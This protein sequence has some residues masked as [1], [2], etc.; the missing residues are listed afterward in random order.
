MAT[1]STQNHFTL[2]DIVNQCDSF[3]YASDS[4]LEQLSF[5]AFMVDDAPVGRIH[6]TLIPHLTSFNQQSRPIFHITDVTVAFMPWISD[7]E[8]RSDAIAQM[9]SHWRGDLGNFPCLSGWRDEL[10]GVYTHVTDPATTKGGAAL[11]IERSACGLFGVHAYGVHL[12]GYV[13]TGPKPSDVQMWVARRSLTK[14][15]Y[16]GML[17]NMV[18]GGMGFGHSPRYTVI[19]ESMEEATIPA[20]IAENAIP[21]GTIS[22][23][24][25][26]KD[27]VQTQPETQIVYDLELPK[28]VIPVP[29]DTEVEDFRLWTME[30]VLYAIRRGEFKPN[31]ACVCLH[32]MIQHAVITPENEPDYLDIV[33]RLH[34]RIE[35]PGPKIWPTFKELR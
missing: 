1:D 34:R 14:Q 15:T 21:V 23:I 26:S 33:Q 30:Q 17:D 13:R 5:L 4:K 32:F 16:P 19:K 2:L 3:P 10:Y 12:N 7:Y 29:C 25:L 6:T 20:D 22:Y 31:C 8:S 24:K 27:C 11:A 28:D 9:L 35:Y 18:A